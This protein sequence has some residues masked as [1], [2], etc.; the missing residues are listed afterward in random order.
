MLLTEHLEQVALRLE[1]RL[2][3]DCFVEEFEDDIRQAILS[4]EFHRQSIIDEELND[5]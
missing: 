2:E 3:T 5:G 1:R 4:I